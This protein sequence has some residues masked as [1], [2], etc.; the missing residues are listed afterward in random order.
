[1]NKKDLALPFVKW[2]GGKRQ[3]IPEICY[4]LPPDFET[5]ITRYAEPFIGG[6]A[7]FFHNLRGFS[8]LNRFY[9][10]DKNRDLISAY[11]VIRGNVIGLIKELEKRQTD[12]L[13]L[14]EE[15]DREFYF[16]ELRKRFNQSSNTEFNLDDVYNP[17]MVVRVAQL[18]FLNKTCYNGLYRVNLKGGFNA[19]HGRY[20]NPTICDPKRL[21][22]VS[23]ILG[24]R[25]VH[26]RHGDFSDCLDFCD[27]NTFVYFD[28]PYRPV[29]K[30]SNFTSYSSSG[31]N[32]AEQSMLALVCRHLDKKGA[33]WM[34][35]NSFQPDG[36]FDG[37]Y[38][39][40]H[41]HVIHANRA[42]NSDGKKRGKVPEILITNYLPS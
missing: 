1:M 42:I 4:R 41:V 39:G 32:D 23:T 9:I 33:K 21:L 34:V 15:D 14:S 12:Y 16:Y 31:F 13:G 37:L 29:S 27:E 8:N 20:K 17:K 22:A 19:P 26:I 38:H 6:G 10:S 7:L 11:S 28:P 2:L 25:D 5:R 40:Y 36:F 3:L 18:L 24:D 30:S 35:S